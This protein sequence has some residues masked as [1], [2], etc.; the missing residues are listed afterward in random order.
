MEHV[1]TLVWSFPIK[2]VSSEKGRISH[3]L[4]WRPAWWNLDRLDR[5]GFL[6]SVLFSDQFIP[7]KGL[8]DMIIGGAMDHSIFPVIC[9]LRRHQ[10]VLPI[11]FY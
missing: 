5:A 9:G 10:I 11:E 3:A 7:V 6:N 4:R 1:D 8:Y 2:I